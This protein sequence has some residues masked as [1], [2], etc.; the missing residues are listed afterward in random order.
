MQYIAIPLL[1]TNKDVAVQALTGSGKTLAYVVPCIELILRKGGFKSNE[2]G[3]LIVT[4]TRE[5]AIQVFNVVCVFTST[6]FLP[7]PLLAI[8]GGAGRVNVSDESNLDSFAVQ[9]AAAAHRTV[10]DD[11]HDFLKNKSD[12]MVGT[13]GRV[14]DLLTRYDAID[15]RSLELLVLDEAD[16]LLSMGFEHQI[17]GILKSLPTMRRT[18]LFSATMTRGVKDLSRAGLRNPVVV[19]VTVDAK[20]DTA[21]RDASDGSDGGAA[22][23]AD[24]I[25]T[26]SSLRN[27]YVVSPLE[28]KISRLAAFLVQHKD[29]KT[30]VFFLTCSCVD[31]YGNALQHLLSKKLSYLESLHGKMV[32]KRRENALSRFRS[33]PCGALLCTDVAARG[34]D[35]TDIEWVVQMDA[36]QE[37]TYFV[38]RVGRAARAGRMGRSVIFLTDKEESYVDFLRLR[39]VPIEEMTDEREECTRPVSAA[40]DAVPTNTIPEILSK[41]KSLVL[42]DRDYLE[43]GTSAFTSYVRAYKE[44]SC[45][46]IFRFPSLDLGK[47]AT[48]FCLLRLPK[49]PEL[50]ENHKSLSFVPAGPEVDIYAIPFKDKVREKAR[51]VRLAKELAAGGKNAKQIKAEKK[52]ADKIRRT[53][54][55]KEEAI[56]KGRNPNKKRGKQQQIYDEWEE[57][58]KE[59]RLN[60]KLRT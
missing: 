15:C 60:K 7:P 27:Y 37:Q 26:P 19:N 1:L 2:L 30:V 55:K 21:P 18:G 31:F 3:A 54:E 16:T 43:K 44:H 24:T 39:K 58:A 48:S 34:L 59:E 25:S 32:Q 57:L 6:A 40:V 9:S 38:H 42:S 53:Q 11:I 17:G 12:V 5:L 35:V 49:M 50:K 10:A 14:H 47:L 36:P 33:A 56:A 23:A 46:F 20:K 4:P 45:T 29:E 13:P 8:G 28:E 51:Q 22:S 52:A 41:I